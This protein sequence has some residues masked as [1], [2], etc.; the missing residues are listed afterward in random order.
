MSK[1]LPRLN[2]FVPYLLDAY[3]LL[4]EALEAEQLGMAPR[5]VQRLARSSAMHTV[6]ALH[7]AANSSLWSEDQ[8]YYETATLAYK[9][10]MYLRIVHKI[11]PEDGLEDMEIATLHELEIASQALNNPQVAQG[12][13]FEHPTKKNLIEFERTPLKKMSCE[14]G[15]WI[16]LYSGCCL[17][18]AVSFLDRF[19]VERCVYD[20]V[21]LEIL[22]GTHASGE[23]RYAT[24][25]DTAQLT[26]L[27]TE[28]DRLLSREAFLTE[29]ASA[30]W[31][32]DPADFDLAL[33]DGCPGFHSA[34]SA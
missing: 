23:D 27:R 3:A 6:G 21:K 1:I 11:D 34:D 20:P 10:D 15:N 8:A 24:G 22:F 2:P 17:G 14:T 33:F 28:V 19:F 4:N 30:R 5:I 16:P 12:Q 31:K 9:F 32:M 18:L 13:H 7:A 26:D 25:F 29:M